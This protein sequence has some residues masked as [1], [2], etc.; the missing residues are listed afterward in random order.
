MKTTRI[1]ATVHK[2]L[3]IIAAKT[4]KKIEDIICDAVKAVIK[5]HKN[6]L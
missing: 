6:Y 2:S 5:K 4:G 1:P 3:K